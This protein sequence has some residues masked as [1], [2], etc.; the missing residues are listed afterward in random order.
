MRAKW[1]CC[2]L[3]LGSLQ[4]ICKA[5]LIFESN[6]ELALSIISKQREL[7]ELKHVGVECRCLKIWG[8]LSFLICSYKTLE[9][10]MI[11]L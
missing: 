8:F 11:S 5:Y 1:F 10:I 3:K 7:L 6:L 9:K 4:L 2:A